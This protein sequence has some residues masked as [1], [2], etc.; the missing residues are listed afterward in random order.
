MSPKRLK[1]IHVVAHQLRIVLIFSIPAEPDLPKK[2]LSEIIQKL[3]RVQVITKKIAYAVNTDI[4]YET[5]ESFIQPK[6]TPPSHRDKISIPHM[7]QFMSNY[8][9]QNNLNDQIAIIQIPYR[10]LETKID[11]ILPVATL[12]LFT[13]EE[14][15]GS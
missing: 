5:S 3:V 15:L 8:Y 1:R 2:V 10:I 12:T 4:L 13:S 11:F 14:T 9:R 6:I 7:S